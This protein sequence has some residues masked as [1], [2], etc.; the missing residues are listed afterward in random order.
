MKKTDEKKNDEAFRWRIA[1]QVVVS[2]ELDEEGPFSK[3]AIEDLKIES[4]VY[5]IAMKRATRRVSSRALN[6]LTLEKRYFKVIW[7]AVSSLSLPYRRSQSRW[8]GGGHLTTVSLSMPGAIGVASGISEKVRS[9]NGKWSGC[10]STWRFHLPQSWA[11]L[12]VNGFALYDG[13]LVLQ[14]H[15]APLSDIPHSLHIVEQS[16]GFALKV[17]EVKRVDPSKFDMRKGRP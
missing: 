16:V 1:H 14:A 7:S 2:R 3:I 10:N 9:T 12:Y 6:R 8:A 17:R 13:K 11:S 15:F 5:E 4:M